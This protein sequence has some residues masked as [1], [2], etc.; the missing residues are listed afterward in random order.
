M[1][2]SWKMAKKWTITIDSKNISI[3]APR[4]DVKADYFSRKQHYAIST[5]GLVSENLVFPSK[6]PHCTRK[7]KMKK[8]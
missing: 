8:P 5:Q 3:V 2:K 7:P 6:I 1:E 4:A